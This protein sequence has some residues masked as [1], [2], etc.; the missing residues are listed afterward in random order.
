[1]KKI[2][3]ALALCM[4]FGGNVFAD[5]TSTTHNS[6]LRGET[7][8][9]TTEDSILKSGDSTTCR[10]NHSNGQTTCD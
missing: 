8:T 10:T 9:T 3:L 5:H 4:V 2:I 6:T 1:M 7:V